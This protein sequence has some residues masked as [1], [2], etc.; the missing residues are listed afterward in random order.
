MWKK[1]TKV[2][3]F[4]LIFILLFLGASKVLNSTGDYRSAQWIGGFYK[5]PARSLDAVYVGSST[6]YAY[7][8]PLYAWENYGIAVYPYTCNSQHFIAAEYLIREVR[9][10]QPDALF[11]VNTNTIE[12]NRM[13]VE[14][15][16]DLLDCMPFSI[17]KLRLTKYLCDI[18]GFSARESLELYVPLYRFH[19]RWSELNSSDFYYPLNGLKGTSNYSTYKNTFTDISQLYTHADGF[20]PLP[21]YIAEA[22]E[23][24]MDY[25]E[26]EGVRIVFVTVPR[27]ESRL[28]LEEINTLNAMLEDRGFDTL[29]LMDQTDLL[30]LDL[31]QDFYNKGHT[32]IHGSLKYTAYLSEY[33]IER[34]GL[35]DRRGDP[36][37]ASWDEGVRKYAKSMQTYT[38]DIERDVSRRTPELPRPDDLEITAGPDGIN[39]SWAPVS[40]ADGYLVYQRPQ[41]KVW[42]LLADVA[43]TQFSLAPDKGKTTD[44]YTVV[45]YCG[46]GDGRL[47]G[48][49]DYCCSHAED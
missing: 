3:L 47:Y 17:N 35:E 37:C 39:I 42:T 24:L 5:E 1:I 36:S 2:V 45:P 40:G 8:N 43:E 27:V 12:E 22:A 15:Y 29:K 49:F 25:C 11:I 44:D 9:K 38:L 10:T 7:W 34:Y 18:S 13:V 16:H 23:S 19:S 26:A 41:G 4:L 32:N 46:S 30:K 28:R 6:C 33:L 20:S 14:K 31:T 48:E 21:D